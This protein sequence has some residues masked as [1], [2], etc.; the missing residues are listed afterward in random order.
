LEESFTKGLFVAAVAE[1]REIKES[2]IQ[3]G[4][5]GYLAAFFCLA[6]R[7]LWAAAIFARPAADM[8]RFLGDAL[9]AEAVRPLLVE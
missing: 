2:H 9:T 7:A 6:H 4:K 8:V 5:G 3:K 1:M